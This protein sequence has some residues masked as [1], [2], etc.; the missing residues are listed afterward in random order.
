VV[1][2][3]NLIFD[4]NADINNFCLPGSGPKNGICLE[5]KTTIEHDGSIGSG[6]RALFPEDR[7]LAYESEEVV[8]SDDFLADKAGRKDVVAALPGQVTVIR[9]TFNK[10]GTYVWHCHILSHEDHGMMRRFEVIPAPVASPRPPCGLFGLSIFCP[11]TGCGVLGRFLG[12]CHR[13]QSQVYSQITD[14][15]S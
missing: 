3:H 12:L 15:A 4:S 10:R 14:Q 13:S 5:G 1:R 11:F 9:A 7:G 6:F 2:R 8:L